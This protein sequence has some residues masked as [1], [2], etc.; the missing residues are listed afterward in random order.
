MAPAKKKAT[1][2]KTAT[3]K[4][5]AAKKKTTAKKKT[6]AKKK[7][8]AKKTAAKKKPAAKVAAKKS[9]SFYLHAYQIK[10]GKQHFRISND[11]LPVF[12]CTKPTCEIASRH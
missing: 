12:I 4:K 3:R 7:P 11:L 8:A 10:T 1:T 5:P 2:K 9:G 6:A